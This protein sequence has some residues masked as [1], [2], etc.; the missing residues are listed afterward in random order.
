[1][2]PV[3]DRMDEPS[4]TLQKRLVLSLLPLARIYP[5]GEKA[6]ELTLNDKE[7]FL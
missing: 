4:E 1:M 5:S 3:K 7:K 6:T 2:C